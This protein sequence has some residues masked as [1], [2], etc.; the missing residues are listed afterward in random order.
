MN[1][2]QYMAEV[3][4]KIAVFGE[5]IRDEI[6]SD[7]EEHF[8]MGMAGGKTEEQICAELGSVDE[9]VAELKRLTGQEAAAE[10]STKAG[11][12]TAAEASVKTGSQAAAEDSTGEGSR[13]AAEDSAGSKAYSW[14]IDV[15][16]EQVRKAVHGLMEMLGRWTGEAVNG[17]ERFVSDLTEETKNMSEKAGQTAQTVKEKADQAAQTVKEKAD[18]AAQTIKEKAGQTDYGQKAIDDISAFAKE[19]AEKSKVFAE[20]IAAGYRQVRSRA[21]ANDCGSDE[22][23][24]DAPNPADSDMSRAEA[25]NPADSDM[26]GAAASAVID[27]SNAANPADSGLTD[28]AAETGSGTDS[29]AMS[30][31]G[32]GT[33]DSV[34][35]ET[36]CGH[37]AVGISDDEAVHFRYENSGTVNQRLAYGFSFRQEGTTVYAIAKK[38]PGTTNF[39]KSISCPDIELEITVPE[40]IKNLAVRSLSGDVECEDV[41]ASQITISTMSGD[42][43][44][45]NCMAKALEAG[46]LSGDITFADGSA[47]D[48]SAT[49]VSGDISL[50]DSTAQSLKAKTTSGDINICNIAASDITAASVSGDV[51]VWLN[52][53]A[54]Y[55]A[56]VKTSCGDISLAYGGEFLEII[57]SGSYVLGNGEMKLNLSTVNGDIS[58]EG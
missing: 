52:D 47:A 45:D 1:K 20:E 12:Q 7:Y 5:D 49:T 37:V 24:D 44:L 32:T 50:E 42:V 43:R 4:E 53:C 51:G 58:V 16:G 22:A 6:V 29:A 38:K 10:D 23:C 11:T 2:Q 25:A 48:L 26:T 3:A 46:T 18:Q 41:S 39:F 40:N 56:H 15:D 33:A 34:I 36:E 31:S 17:A 21:G 28:A 14:N 54:G 35:I 57:R 30:G 8:R 9:L 55:L 27:Q 19:V 13:A